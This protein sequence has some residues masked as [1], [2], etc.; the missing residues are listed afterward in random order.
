MQ[1]QRY[2]YHLVLVG[3]E[4]ILLIPQSPSGLPVF[5]FILINPFSPH[6]GPHEFLTIT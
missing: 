2:I 3:Y 4:A 1:E 6:L 5:L